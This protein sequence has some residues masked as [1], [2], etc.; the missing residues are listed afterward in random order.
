MDDHK[1]ES[2]VHRSYYKTDREIRKKLIRFK[3]GYKS[4]R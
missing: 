2:G 3:F 4:L 1:K